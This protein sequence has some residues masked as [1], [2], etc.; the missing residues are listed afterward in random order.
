MICGNCKEHHLSVGEVRACYADRRE[1]AVLSR[2]QNRSVLADP[3]PDLS[4]RAEPEDPISEPLRP[5]GEGFYSYQ[6]VIHKVVRAIHGSGHLYAK[7]LVYTG[8]DSVM[9]P[10]TGSQKLVPC[11]E[12]Q[13][14]YNWR[15]TLREE[16]RL[17]QEEALAYGQMYGVCCICGITL[18]DEKSIERGIGPVCLKKMGWE[19]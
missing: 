13:R 7:K 5:V 16:M 11:A 14:A 8:E 3:Q 10:K 1:S 19:L 18:T 2:P 9:D 17:T 4:L 12:W 6:G 15:K